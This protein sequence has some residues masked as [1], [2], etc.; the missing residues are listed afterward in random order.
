VQLKDLV[1]PIDQ[2][3]DDELLARLREIRH[4]REIIRPAARK[5]VERAETK[6]SRGKVAST[7]KLLENLT[8]DERET[9]LAKLLEQEG[10]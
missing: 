10:P 5:H 8:D 3:T 6:A 9:L 4:R 7:E 1:K 2:Q